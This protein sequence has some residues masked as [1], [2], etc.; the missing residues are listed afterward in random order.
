MDRSA[1]HGPQPGTPIVQ[2]RRPLLLLH[3][4]G[5]VLV[6]WTNSI[7]HGH[8]ARCWPANMAPILVRHREGDYGDSEAVRLSSVQRPA[9]SAWWPRNH[10]PVNHFK[11]LKPGAG[12]DGPRQTGDLSQTPSTSATK[13]G[14]SRASMPLLWGR[15]HNLW[16][17]NFPSQ[18][19]LGSPPAPQRAGVSK[20]RTP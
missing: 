20:V 2:R 4:G 15:F 18:N 7:R 6:S 10:D 12:R 19:P 3:C 13:T 17:S 8:C 5:G 1:D 14:S 16:T 11:I 9:D